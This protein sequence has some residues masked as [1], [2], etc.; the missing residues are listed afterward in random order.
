VPVKEGF[1]SAKAY[2]RKAIELDESLA[3]AHASL[4][5]RL[6]IYDWDWTAAEREFR[7]AI[8]L[9]PGFATGH[10]WY[11]FLLI[12]RGQVE[13]ALIEAHMSQELDPASVSIRR[14]LGGVYA[15]ARRYEQARFHTE[16]AIAMNPLAEESYRLLGMALFRLGKVEEAERVLRES[17]ALPGAGPYADATLGYVLAQRGKTDEAQ[18]ICGRLEAAAKEGYVSPVAFGTLCLGLGQWDSALD[19]IQRSIDERRGWFV[20]ARV[21]PMFDPI[22]EHPRFLSML[23]DLDRET[24]TTVKAGRA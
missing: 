1:E 7:R 5:W 2:A 19:W 24:S 15:Y 9:A 13:E 16:R 4:A 10:Q 14:G 12:A 18:A 20:Y 21:N 23:K 3:D 8:E 6:F 17:A 22:R 11:A